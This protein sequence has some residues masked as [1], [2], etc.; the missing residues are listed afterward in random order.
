MD[1]RASDILSAIIDEYI[2][3]GEPVGSKALAE[4]HDFGVSS[5]TIRNTMAAL[6]QEGYLGHPH[7]SAGRVPT[8]KG[9][10]YYVE[11]LMNPEPVDPQL[12]NVI[13]SM[14]DSNA[15]SDDAIVQNA[16]TA[17]A[18]ITKCATV[19]T[20]HSSKF[21]VI[22]KVDVIP[23]GRRMYVLLMIASN[24]SIK[25]KVC[26]MEYDLT[27]EQ[28]ADFTKFLN[29]H[30]SGVNLEN[31]SEEYISNLSAALEGYMLAL[32]PLLHAVFE[33]SEE[34]MRDNVE[35]KGEA[36]LLSCPEFPMQE[37]VNFIEHKAELSG[38]LDEAFS[39][40][41]IQFGSED[42]TFAISNGAMVSVNYY[43]DGKPAG[44][45]GVVGPMR[46]DY[47]KVI[48]YVEY[49]SQKVTTLLSVEN[50]PKAIESDIESKEGN[51]DDE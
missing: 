34:M 32:S 27:N 48:P 46:L 11:N 5:A 22:T 20:N 45:L 12:I 17:L 23:T 50:S 16:S 15:L 9:F 47:R 10:R 4:K 3:T 31:M 37:I 49:L 36:N 35:V 8:Y 44:T 24:G 13:D 21:S 14:L 1:K 38:L 40:I 18:E 41:N 6:E 7:T 30:L 19:A 25:N 39:G 33:L 51:K 28:T 2:R 42:G 29:E 26:R 43:K